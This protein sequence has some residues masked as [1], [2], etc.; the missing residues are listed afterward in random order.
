MLLESVLPEFFDVDG[1][2][3]DD[4][5]DE[6]CAEAGPR[7][8]LLRERILELRELGLVGV[9]P[10]VTV[11]LAVSAATGL[12]IPEPTPGSMR[13]RRVGPYILIDLLGRGGQGEVYLALDSRLGRRVALKLLS[14]RLV[15]QRARERMRREADSLSRLDHPGICTI[16]EVGEDHGMPY[17]AMRF[18]DGDP[19][20][21]RIAA[22][23]D[24]SGGV[25]RVVDLPDRTESSHD[26]SNRSDPSTS[27][28]TNR[29]TGSRHAVL[30]VVE[31]FERIARALHSAHMA[32]VIHRDVKP[33]NILISPGGDPVLVDFGLA[34]VEDSNDLTK[35]GDLI[36]TPAYMAP[37]QLAGKATDRRS[38]VYSL[39]VTLYESLSGRRPFEGSKDERE[40]GPA[41]LY[42]AVTSR[43]MPDPRNLNGSIPSDLVTVLAKALD[44]E[45]ARRYA[46]A[47][48]LAQDL[49][50]V[51]ES[52][53]VAAR[54][55]TA[56]GRTARWVR[57]EPAQ[58][59]L[60]L[61][62]ILAIPSVAGL[63]GYLLAQ[64]PLAL[65]GRQAQVDADF[66]EELRRGYVSL[67]S[68]HSG[69]ALASFRNALALRPNDE[70]AC[71]GRLLALAFGK[72]PH[73]ALT[74]IE[75]LDRSTRRDWT[76]LGDVRTVAAQRSG[77]AEAAELPE[78][79]DASSSATK[80]AVAQFVRGMLAREQAEREPDEKEAQQIRA[81]AL[82]L[83]ARAVVSAEQPRQFFHFWVART[84]AELGDEDMSRR[85]TDAIASLWPESPDAWQWIGMVRSRFDP[86]GALAA[87][88]RAIE[89]DPT[90]IDLMLSVG[91]ARL[92]NGDVDGARM[93]LR[94]AQ[95]L[96]PTNSDPI[97]FLGMVDLYTDQ[98]DD[99]KRRF[100]RA[101]ELSPDNVF[102]HGL[103]LQLYAQ[104]EDSE[105]MAME[106]ARWHSVPDTLLVEARASAAQGDLE[107]AVLLAERAVA[108]ADAQKRPADQIVVMRQELTGFRAA[109]TK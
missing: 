107:R 91:T 63:G 76:W 15:S 11:D 82:D 5:L 36:G 48:D 26:D 83:L 59:G 52:R 8:E 44:P 94:R 93:V 104:R 10:D 95:E 103:L 79:S 20:S 71:A 21:T 89:L 72:A 47:F 49:R 38:D 3:F 67:G 66:A 40:H 41:G 39:A 37:E 50:A 9:G 2:H 32:G 22:T 80:R 106:N 102:A 98:L 68:G 56:F 54:P 99:A 96:F 70:E 31:L 13:G 58:A 108:A 86:L 51:G 6:V 18:I 75:D 14:Q 105:A 61:V 64:R 23:R 46:T 101:I 87:N 42:R 27:S 35:T 4:R 85:Y 43:Q 81:R 78:Q 84:A 25:G 90:R 28:S 60:A 1:V 73:E 62:L 57:R 30:R 65:A 55:V 109:A 97:V 53:P 33:Q 7:G 24:A 19:L 29:T 12:D 100:L 17:L 92:D 74:V 88:E 34:D 16:F 69:D 77:N 45:P